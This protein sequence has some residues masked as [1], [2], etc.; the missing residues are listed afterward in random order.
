[1][2]MRMWLMGVGVA[3]VAAGTLGAVLLWLL[4]T[5]PLAVARMFGGW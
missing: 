3:G 1:M 2:A 5:R 4:A